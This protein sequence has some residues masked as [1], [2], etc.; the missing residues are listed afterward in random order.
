MGDGERLTRPTCGLPGADERSDQA[1]GRPVLTD[2]DITAIALT[3]AALVYLRR[4]GRDPHRSRILIA[5]ARHLPI[6]SPLLVAA[7][8]PDISLWNRAAATR[9]R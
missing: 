7:G 8:F 9:F 2:E 1:G 6:L 4:L 5:D 3:A